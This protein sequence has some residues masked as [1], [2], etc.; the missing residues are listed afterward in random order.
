[1]C[2][3]YKI[4]SSLFLFF[5]VLTVA[6]LFFWLYCRENDLKLRGRRIVLMFVS[7]NDVDHFSGGLSGEGTLKK[8]MF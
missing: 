4:I 1:M 2:V 6:S 7:D 8:K 3:Q 5:L